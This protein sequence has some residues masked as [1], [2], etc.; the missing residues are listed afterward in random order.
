VNYRAVRVDGTAGGY[1]AD[2][3]DNDKGGGGAV[4]SIVDAVG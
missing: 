2:G 3:P 4:P 1:M